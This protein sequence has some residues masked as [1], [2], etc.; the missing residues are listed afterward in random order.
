MAATKKSTRTRTTKAKTATTISEVKKENTNAT[1][2]D[3]RELIKD[4]AAEYTDDINVENHFDEIDDEIVDNNLNII[5]KK[6]LGE[7]N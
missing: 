1:D 3:I 7:D 5:D 6:I 4:D 2:D